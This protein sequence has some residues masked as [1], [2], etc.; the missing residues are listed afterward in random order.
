[1]SLGAFAANLLPAVSA[2]GAPRVALMAD[3]AA[4]PRA[5]ALRASELSAF[6][7]ILVAAGPASRA[8]AILPAY[9]A[10]EDAV[11]RL[12]QNVGC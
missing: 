10:I 4:T 1:M 2:Q 3:A 11:L 8:P 5:V 12:P 6:A 7:G 9:A